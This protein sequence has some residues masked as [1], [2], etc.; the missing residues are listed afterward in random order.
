ML[1]SPTQVSTPGEHPTLRQN[2]AVD[3]SSKLTSSIY[4]STPGEHPTLTQK[5][6]TLLRVAASYLG[7]ELSEPPVSPGSRRILLPN[8]K[9]LSGDTV[10]FP[11]GGA[12]VR[13][14]FGCY[15]TMSNLV[16]RARLLVVHHQSRHRVCKPLPLV[17]TPREGSGEEHVLSP[18]SSLITERSLP[19]VSLPP[20]LQTG[21]VSPGGRPG[22]DRSGQQLSQ[23]HTAK[24]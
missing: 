10:A 23:P 15:V 12:V 4:L 11:A 2:A 7:E 8:M 9:V 20:R 1:S 18:G 16:C 21:C 24:V 13:Y 5:Q 3:Q 17:V 14:T 6:A 22:Q 19:S